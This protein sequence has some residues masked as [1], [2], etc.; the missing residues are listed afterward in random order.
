M[1]GKVRDVMVPLL[2]EQ[3]EKTK[4]PPLDQQTEAASFGCGEISLELVE[5]PPE[6]IILDL[7]GDIIA[8]KVPDIIASVKQFPW[9]YKKNSFPKIK[10]DGKATAKA[11]GGSVF[12]ELRVVPSDSGISLEVETSIVEIHKLD[13]KISGTKASFAYNFLISLF[14]SQIKRYLEQSLSELIR[15]SIEEH[16][17]QLFGF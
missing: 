3:L 5:I 17:S 14:S 13:V 6:K 11:T 9:H 1:K 2:K 4:L 7:N 16:A 15:N 10:D 12:I 8:F